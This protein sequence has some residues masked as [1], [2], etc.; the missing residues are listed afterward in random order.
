MKTTKARQ[1]A[2]G[3]DCMIRL[4]GICNGN[5]ETV[6][7]AHYRLSGLCGI[8]SKP[9]DLLGAWACSC[10]HDACDRRTHKDLDRDY[11]RLCH[12]EGVMRT[13]DALE[14]MK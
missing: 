9:N 2:R 1:A 4:P 7:L 13:I 11:V 8:G 5:P 3:Q 12:A 6:V 14:R 10:C